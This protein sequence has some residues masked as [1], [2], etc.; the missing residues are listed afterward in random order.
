[1]NLPPPTPINLPLSLALAGLDPWPTE[2]LAPADLFRRLLDLAVQHRFA[3]VQ[4]NAA[5]PQMRARD[6]SRSARRDL[7]SMLRRS[8]LSFS[9][10]D[11]WIPP[12]HFVSTQ[13]QD[14]AAAAVVDALE[15]CADMRMLARESSIGSGV[16]R[17]DAGGRAA[18]V[19]LNLPRATPPAIKDH[20]ASRAESLGVPLADHTFTTDPAPAEWFAGPIKPGLDPAAVF[21]GG[22]DP[23]SLAARLGSSL[24]SARLSDVSSSGRRAAGVSNASSGRLDVSTYAVTLAAVG[25]PGPMVLDLRDVAEPLAAIDSAMLAWKTLA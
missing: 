16:T 25:Y 4:M 19:S 1:M 3:G 10:L 22:G 6:L 9:G 17:G 7:A 11:L 2:S 13:H 12:E 15:L 23:I 5:Q 14:R 8:R 20:L 18:C 24:A 21:T